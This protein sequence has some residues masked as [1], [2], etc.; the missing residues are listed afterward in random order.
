MDPNWKKLTPEEARVIDGK[1]T[2]MAFTGEYWNH[3]GD[4]SYN[5]KRCGQPLFA[6]DSKFDSGTGWPSFDRALPGAVREIPDADGRRT[7]IVCAKCG[8][9]LGHVFRGEGMTDAGVRHCV[10]SVSLDFKEGDP[11][12]AAAATETETAYFAGGC[13]WGVEYHF[14]NLPGVIAA[15]SGYMGGRVESPSYRQVSGGDTGH[16]EAVRVTFD[17]KRV[18]YETLARLFFEIH[19]P[20]QVDRQGPD[21]GKQ[22]RS[23]VFTKNDEQKQIIEKL[24]A[25]LTAK[26]FKVATKIEPAG[27]FWPAEDY[28]QD[29]YAKKGDE[30]YCHARVKRF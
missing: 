2:E 20:T 29:Y 14:E 27:A 17:P 3:H 13:F 4:G 8:A 9:H 26:G 24:I 22:Y 7:E 11:T 21:V 23:E 6:S 18:D 30:P 16:A 10:N 19:D 5:C 1:G 15:E 25:E 12:C 28:H